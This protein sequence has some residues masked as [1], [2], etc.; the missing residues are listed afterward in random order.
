MLRPL[1]VMMNRKIRTVSPDAALTEA[2][3][4]MRE[5]RNVA[6]M[7]FEQGS[8]VGM[9]SETDLERKAMAGGLD[10]AQTRVSTVM[11][12][13]VIT[14]EIDRSAPAASDVMAEKGMRHVA[15]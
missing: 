2:A 13:P 4:L 10:P 8:Y 11:S 1:A 15:I 9:V 7:V 14:I 3:G 6:L 12:S 5:T